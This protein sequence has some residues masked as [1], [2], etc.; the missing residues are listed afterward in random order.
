MSAADSTNLLDTPAASRLRQHR[1]LFYSD[2]LGTVEK[3]R[4]YGPPTEEWLARVREAF[5]ARASV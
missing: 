1:G 2:E 4:P 5:A 3:F